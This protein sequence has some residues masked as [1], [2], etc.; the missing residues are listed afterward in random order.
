MDSAAMEI[1]YK[2]APGV[3]QTRPVI[4]PC[5]API[6]D[7][8]PKKAT[9]KH[10][11]IRRLV[12]AHTLVFSTA[13]DAVLLAAYGAPPLKPDHPIHSSP[14]PAS[15]NSILFGE[16]LSLSLFSLGPTYRNHYDNYFKL[17]RFIKEKGEH[18]LMIVAR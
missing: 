9:S 11:H 2:P 17:R 3:M 12:A 6:T 1:V 4:I 7:G 5:T 15:I 13:M 16:N 14:A 8:L 18:L 10:V